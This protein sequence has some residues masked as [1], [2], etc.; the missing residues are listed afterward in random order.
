[1]IER[2][3]WANLVLHTYSDKI[4]LY[5]IVEKNKVVGVAYH[6]KVDDGESGMVD[7]GMYGHGNPLRLFSVERMAGTSTRKNAAQ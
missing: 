4:F 6:L 7:S 3:L 5:M 2:I 1:M